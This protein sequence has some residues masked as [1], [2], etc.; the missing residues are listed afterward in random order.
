MSSYTFPIATTLS[1]YLAIQPDPTLIEKTAL[2]N[3]NK[4]SP[5]QKTRITPLLKASVPPATA[6]TLIEGDA[7]TYRL[8]VAMLGQSVPLSTINSNIASIGAYEIRWREGVLACIESGLSFAD[9]KT[10][11][12]RLK[13]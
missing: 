8:V 2:I 1:Q 11:I 12:D 9:A 4:L 6:L 10:L 3:F 5:E 13:G 7:I